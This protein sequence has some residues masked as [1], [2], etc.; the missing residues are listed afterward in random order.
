MLTPLTRLCYRKL[1]RGRSDRPAFVF[2]MDFHALEEAENASA[3]VCGQEDPDER[4]QP[5]QEQTA[6]GQ[7][8]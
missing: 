4:H 6:H 1:T 2:I 7:G 8:Y 3:Q 5:G